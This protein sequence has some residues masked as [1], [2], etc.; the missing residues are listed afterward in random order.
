MRAGMRN[1]NIALALAFGAVSGIASA[2]LPSLTP[3]Q[4]QAAAAKKQQAAAQ[5]EKEKQELAASMDRIASRWRAR[6]AENG[7]K[8]NPPTP[9]APVP[10][11]NA[12][13][14]QSGPSGQPGGK[15]GNAAADAP[16]RSEK[17]G[18]APPSE[19]VKDPSR[20]GK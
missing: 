9:V 18:T 3:E 7:W 5:A 10:G 17:S 20:K 13:A 6:A 4:E 19:D 8:T 14:T 12:S 11:F 15:L 1:W 2:R 16:I